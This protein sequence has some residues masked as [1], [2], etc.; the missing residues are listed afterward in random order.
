MP[1]NAALPRIEVPLERAQ[2]PWSYPFPN[3]QQPRCIHVVR[4]EANSNEGGPQVT[5]PTF[6]ARSAFEQPQGV[7]VRFAQIARKA[8]LK[9]RNAVPAFRR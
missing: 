8:V 4:T 6:F 9:V 3:A 7:R 5:T 1:Q 2:Y